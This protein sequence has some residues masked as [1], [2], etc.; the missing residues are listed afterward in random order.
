MKYR[1]FSQWLIIAYFVSSFLIAWISRDYWRRSSQDWAYCSGNIL[2]SLL[3]AFTGFV[4]VILNTVSY[5]PIAKG[6]RSRQIVPI[7]FGIC[8]AV[9]G[10]LLLINQL[11]QLSAG[12]PAPG[13]GITIDP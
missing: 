8:W 5:H 12:C 4:L 1:V 7:A 6:N 11:Q 9:I 13:C 3:S 2:V 10:L